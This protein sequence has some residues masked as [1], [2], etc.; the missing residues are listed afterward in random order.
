MLRESRNPGGRMSEKA[1]PRS[2]EAQVK[3]WQLRSKQSPPA[4]GSGDAGEEGFAHRAAAEICPYQSLRLLERR[5]P[6]QPAVDR[7]ITVCVPSF[8]ARY[9]RV[10]LRIDQL[11]HFNHDFPPL[12]G[13]H[14][15]H[16]VRMTTYQLR[17]DCDAL[18]TAARRAALWLTRIRM[19][20]R[21]PAAS[22]AFSSAMG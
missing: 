9:Q 19:D 5:L 2:G 13:M 1:R 8:P 12:R 16:P 20:L 22:W 15:N 6:R 10:D 21:C 17:L 11:T 18:H 4:A 7:A 14:V 3:R